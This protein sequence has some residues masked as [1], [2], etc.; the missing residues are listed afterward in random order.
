MVAPWAWLLA[1]CHHVTLH[2][3]PNSCMGSERPETVALPVYTD[4]EREKSMWPCG[5]LLHK[6]SPL[7]SVSRTLTC[8][9]PTL[10]SSQQGLQTAC[11]WAW[12]SVF[13]LV[14]SILPC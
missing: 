6:V 13:L 2:E 8:S 3:L 11:A 9:W 14:T 1:D 5:S 12:A 7:G 10:L 4:N